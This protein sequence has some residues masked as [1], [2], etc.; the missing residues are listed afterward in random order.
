MHGTMRMVVVGLVLAGATGTSSMAQPRES[1]ITIPYLAN[2]STPDALDFAA[3]ICEVATDGQRMQCHVRQ[4]FITPTSM[5]PTNCAVTTNGYDQQFRLAKPGQWISEEE[6]GGECGLV[7]TT[8]LEDGGATRW[9]MTVATRA[10]TNLDRPSC[11][12]VAAPEL[13][14]YRT[15]R[16][17]LPCTTVQPGAIER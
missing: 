7:E 5:D 6:Q 17:K 16:R 13:Y 10:T 8:T 3:A 4:L 9:T 11:R 15:L 14:D 1:R 12:T 2:A